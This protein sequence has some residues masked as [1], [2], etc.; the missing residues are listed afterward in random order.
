MADDKKSNLRK[1]FP[2]GLI[3]LLM[4]IFLFAFMLQTYIDT[5]FAKV[6]FSYELEHLVNL[7]LL[8]PE[9]SKKVA[10]SDNLVTFAVK[11]IYNTTDEGKNRFKFLELLNQNH[12]LNLE[13]EVLVKDHPN[14]KSKVVESA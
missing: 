7:Q 11:Y 3:W 8:Q 13:K 12:E 10:L 9:D 4:A 5:K 14:L 1:N 6:S 2:N